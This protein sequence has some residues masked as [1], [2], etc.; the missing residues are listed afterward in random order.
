MICIC[1]FK[2][3]FYCI[4][5]FVSLFQTPFQPEDTACDLCNTVIKL[6]TPFI[7]SSK[8]EA[9]VKKDLDDICAG[10]T[11]NFSKEVSMCE[12]VWGLLG[13]V[14]CVRVCVV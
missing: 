11:G 7:D 2:Y 1:H 13:Y 6:I 14:R 9:D 8:D 4:N 10:I 3:M 5:R 12:G